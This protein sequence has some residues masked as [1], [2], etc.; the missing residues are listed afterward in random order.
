MKAYCINCGRRVVAEIEES[1]DEMILNGKKVSFMAKELICQECG[2]PIGD[3]ELFLENIERAIEIL[4]QG[5]G[6]I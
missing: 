6:Y 1:P 2:E 3:D 5:E 4:K